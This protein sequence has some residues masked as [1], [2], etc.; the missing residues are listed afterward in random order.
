MTCVSGK[1]KL[2]EIG[3][4]EI[5]LGEAYKKLT[6]ESASKK[7]IP[8]VIELIDKVNQDYDS[9]IIKKLIDYEFIDELKKN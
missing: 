8:P 4:D 7:D 9:E 5:S 3:N 6:L 2:Y 1:A